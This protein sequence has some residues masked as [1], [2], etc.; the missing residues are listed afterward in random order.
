MPRQPEP[1]RDRT[2]ALLDANDWTEFG[3]AQSILLDA[4]IGSDVSSNGGLAPEFY[5]GMDGI[6][7][8]VRTLR[9]LEKDLARAVEALRDAWGPEK[10]VGRT[11]LT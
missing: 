7:T 11:P 10:L 6:G 1:A 2:V 8:G 5:L 3:L 9:V 4:G